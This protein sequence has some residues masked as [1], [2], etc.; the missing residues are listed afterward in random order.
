MAGAPRKW[1]PFT[2]VS[3]ASG[4]EY[5]NDG[6]IRDKHRNRITDR[7]DGAQI[8]IALN[9]KKFPKR[10]ILAMEFHGLPQCHVCCICGKGPRF[11]AIH[12]NRDRRD[13]SRDNLKWIAVD[14]EARYH[15]R[16]C[17]EWAMCHNTVPPRGRTVS[18]TLA[19]HDPDA[20]DDRRVLTRRVNENDNWGPTRE[21]IP[22]LGI[23]ERT[24]VNRQGEI[25]VSD[26]IRM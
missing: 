24:R 26:G 2:T 18:R 11:Q 15:E 8:I 22:L 23:N 7:W 25:M 12:L 17:I 21:E 6:R 9:G 20:P 5:T 13:F 3:W 16:R 10:D 19:T 1:Y 4:Y 14:A